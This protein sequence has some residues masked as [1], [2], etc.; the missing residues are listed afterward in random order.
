MELILIS[1]ILERVMC[2]VNLLSCITP[3]EQQ[4]SLLKLIQP[5]GNLIETLSIIQLRRP[6]RKRER[7]TKVSCKL[8]Q[9]YRIWITMKGRKWLM[10]S[11]RKRLRPAKQLS[12]KEKLEKSFTSSLKEKPRQLSN[13]LQML[14]SRITVPVTTSENVHFLAENQE[15]PT[16]LL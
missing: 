5:C 2:S 3:Q 4:P 7:S 16:S 8:F 10:L 13:R 14:Q 1:K 9:F 11:K 12:N 6:L 15:L